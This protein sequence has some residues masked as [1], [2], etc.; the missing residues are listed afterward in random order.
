MTVRN[1]RIAAST[2]VPM[3]FLAGLW[4]F[5]AI[6]Q[7]ATLE[8]RSVRIASSTPGATTEHRFSFTIAS[9]T[10]LGSIEFE[11]C[12]NDPFIGTACTPPTG[13]SVS[14]AVLSSQTGET[15]FGIHASTTTNRLV[16]SR[17][18]VSAAAQPVTY[19][20]NG[21]VNPS[22][23]PQTVYIRISTFASDD[24]SG[25]RT[26]SGAVVFATASGV[27]VDGFVPPYITFCAGVTVALD[28]ST[29]S[30]TKLDFGELSAAA[31]RFTTSQ[32]AGAT[33]DESG[34]A[35]ST[36]GT[37][38]T[39]GANTI[40]A[41]GSPSVSSTGTGQFGMNLR[42]NTAP[43]VGA[44][45][46]GSGSTVPTSNYN[47]P[48]MFKF[49]NETIASSSISTDYNRFTVSYILN[50]ANGQAPGVYSTTLTFIAFASF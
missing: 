12:S 37:T 30:G 23:P 41:L 1:F 45:P 2:V 29:S 44:E 33:N 9:A 18:P 10:Q 47:N 17:T 49:Q 36:S 25:S 6:S 19:T 13:L 3:L 14:G 42:A 21:I 43:S 27:A 22:A 5:T 50:M 16:I 46:V 24:A 39:S 35:V 8:Q 15:G 26:D 48:D 34:Y 28:C 7:A 38:M 20:F 40:S 32:F 31:T 4:F 11:Y